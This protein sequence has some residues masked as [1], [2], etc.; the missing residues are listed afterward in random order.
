MSRYKNTQKQTKKLPYTT[1]KAEGQHFGQ[2]A[3][4][5]KALMKMHRMAPGRITHLILCDF[6]Y[7]LYN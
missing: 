3:R 7:V 2:R 6:L 5:E 1:E 4:Q